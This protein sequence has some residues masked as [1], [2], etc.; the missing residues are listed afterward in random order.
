M[1]EPLVVQARQLSS[2]TIATLTGERFYVRIDVIRQ[3]FVEF[4]ESMEHPCDKWQHAWI[5]FWGDGAVTYCED[6]SGIDGVFP[7]FAY[8]EEDVCD[9]E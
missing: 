8:R 3:Q 2:G 4:C 1:L 7:G 9:C 6:C 5:R